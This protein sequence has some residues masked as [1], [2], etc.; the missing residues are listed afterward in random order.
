MLYLFCLSLGSQLYTWFSR[1]V[2][3]SS[4]KFYL[5]IEFSKLLCI[6]FKPTNIICNDINHFFLFENDLE[7][8]IAKNSSRLNHIDDLEY[9]AEKNYF[10]YRFFL[11][12]DEDLYL[13]HNRSTVSDFNQFGY[14]PM[15]YDVLVW[16]LR[17]LNYIL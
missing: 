13:A 8:F 7:K 10:E 9:F 15:C 1:K 12:L 17:S 11:G 16:N 5:K 2:K 4:Q 14:V 3:Q 6:S